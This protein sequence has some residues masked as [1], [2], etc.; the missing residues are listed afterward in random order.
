MQTLIRREGTVIFFI[1]TSQRGGI[2]HTIT[3]MLSLERKFFVYVIYFP[4]I[5]K[6]FSKHQ[7]TKHT[8]V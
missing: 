5:I 6:T 3:R 2:L 4:K 7:H 1:A 8:E